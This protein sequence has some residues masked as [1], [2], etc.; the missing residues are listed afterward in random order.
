MDALAQKFLPSLEKLLLVDCGLG[1]RDIEHLAVAI[2]SGGC[3]KLVEMKL[4]DYTI[5]SPF[6]KASARTYETVKD[7]TGMI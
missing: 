5:S 7:R 2:L 3:R 4:G 1:D 6:G